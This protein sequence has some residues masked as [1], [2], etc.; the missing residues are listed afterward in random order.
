MKKDVL[1]PLREGKELSL[2]QQ[3]ALIIRL[4]LPAMLAQVSMIAMQYIDSA[5]VGRLGAGPSAS[6]GLVSTTTWLFGGLCTA[7]TA[8]F[9]VQAAQHL[10]ADEEKRAR[11]VMKHGLCVA[12]IFSAL[13]GVLGALLAPWLPVWLGGEESIRQGAT[14]YFLVFALSVPTVMFH[15]VAGGMLQASGNMRLPSLIYVAMCVLDVVFN[16]FLIFPRVELGFCS[17]PGFDLGVLGASLGTALS[18]LVAAVWMTLALLFTSRSLRLRRGEKTAF[19]GQT[20]RRAWKIGAP[21]ALERIVTNGAQIAVTGVIAP[22]GAVSIA[23]NTF[24]VTAEGLGYMPAYG[25]ADAATAII[26]QSVG[27]RR[28]D[29]TPRLGWLCTLLGMALMVISGLFLYF[30]GPA[31]MHFFTDDPDVA[32]LGIEILRIEAFAESLFGASIVAMGVFRGAGNTLIPSLFNFASMWGIRLPLAL[33]LAPRLGLRGVW[34]AMAIELCV[35]GVLFLIRLG[36]KRWQAALE[37]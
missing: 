12:A 11:D 6:I 24:A 15:Y 17:L 37:G 3:F 16:A 20:L 32:A 21:V 2:G 22:L 30:G 29:L 23:A 28:R 35:R 25:I 26:G 34:L 33:W 8:G 27:A 36:G 31:M 10:G 4:S 18:D 1:A 14:E 5:M 19:D 13:L 9:C 7:L